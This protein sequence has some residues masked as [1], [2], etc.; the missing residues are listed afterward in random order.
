M[1]GAIFDMDGLLFDTEKIWQRKWHDVADEM[2]VTLPDEFKN[3]ITGSSGPFMNKVVCKYYHV[4]DGAEIIKDVYERVHTEAQ[5]HVDMKKGV[6]EIL[7]YLKDNGFLIAVASSSSRKQILHNIQ[8]AGIQNY[9]DAIVSGVELSRGKPAPDIFLKAAEQIKCRPEDCYVFEDAI[10]GVTA[11]HAAGCKTVMIPD[12]LEP[13][14]ETIK[15]TVM[16]CKDLIEAKEAIR[17]GKI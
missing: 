6:V 7:D 9:F 4:E 10:N 16:V 1:D 17:E 5:A 8:S 15:K 12:M 2:G 3:E 11:G 13:D 14:E